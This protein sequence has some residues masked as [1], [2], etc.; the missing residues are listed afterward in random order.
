MLS[1]SENE[2]RDHVFEHHK[3]DFASLIVGERK[4]IEWEGEGFPPIRFLLQRKAERKINEVLTRLKGLTLTAKELRLE[5]TTP[6]PTR[7]DLFGNSEATGITIIE[8]K[9]SGQ[10]ERQSFTEL[11]AY[12][13]HF[14]SIF[15]GLTELAITS[16]LVAPMETR[17]VKDAY[18]QELIFNKKNILA[19]IPHENSGKFTLEVFYPD[20]SYYKSFE[21]NF[22]NDHSMACVTLSFPM[23]DGWIDSDVKTS[24][25]APPQYSIDALNTMANTI[26]HQLEASGFHSIVYAN[27]KWGEIAHLCRQPNMIVVAA[28]NPYSSARTSVHEGVIYGASESDR[29]NNVQSIY[30]QMTD[31]AKGWHWVDAMERNFLGRLIIEI[32]D[33]FKLAVRTHLDD[34]DFH[35]DTCDWYGLKTSFVEAVSVHNLQTYTTGLLR[36]MHLEYV[37]YVYDEGWDEIYYHDGLPTYSYEMLTNFLATWEIF[38]S[39]GL[40]IQEN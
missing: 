32:R 33:T 38:S 39:L 20:E 5:R 23:I 21:N 25:G 12:S 29:R 36:S 13:N 3:D 10:T 31:E 15:P 8:L 4:E 11:L 34:I 14:C 19:L 18:I 22:I 30:D 16:V 28:V 37:N 24:T 2:F 7:I 6:H 9:K 26:S 35:L 17:T 1:I 27:Q 40:D